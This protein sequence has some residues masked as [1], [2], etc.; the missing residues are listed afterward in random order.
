MPALNA[1][2]EPLPPLY[3]GWMLELLEGAIPRE[4]RATCNNCAMCSQP[5]AE[6][7][8]RER[9]FDPTIKCCTYIPVLPNFLVGRILTDDDPAA[10]PG[11]L[12]VEKRIK[13]GVAVTPLGLGPST[14]YLLLYDNIDRNTI[15]RSRALRCPYYLEDG[16]RC[17]IWRNRNSMCATWFCKHGRGQLG[18]FFWRESLLSLLRLIERDL[19]FWCLLQLGFDDGLRHLMKISEQNEALTAE[20]IDNRAEPERQKLLWAGWS[21]RER[22]LYIK[23]AEMVAGLSWSDVLG[24]CGPQVHTYSRLT[25]QAFAELTTDEIPL[26]LTV[27]TMQIAEIKH[28]ITRVITYSTYDPIEVPNVVMAL[29]HHF[30]G[31]PTAEALDEIATKTGIRLEP[32][33]V[34]KMVDFQLL[35]SPNSGP[36]A[37]GD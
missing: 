25:K 12:A 29:L 9:Y 18:Y 37:A 16:G 13:E 11:R 27:G 21:G 1:E 17:G 36:Q 34:R 4:S 3:D 20:S 2:R 22:D 28:D 26:K 6:S 8:P 23:C 31:R 15:G 35:V 7:G 5:G 30:D 24:L 19:T 10:R 14:T 33:L 32:S